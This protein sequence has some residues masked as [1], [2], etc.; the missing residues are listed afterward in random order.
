LSPFFSRHLDS[1]GKKNKKIK[2]KKIIYT[3]QYIVMQ[4]IGYKRKYSGDSGPPRKTYKKSARAQ[5]KPNPKWVARAARQYR[6]FAPETKYFDT[7]FAASV[8]AAGTSWAD[9]E[10]PMTS[11]VNS[12]GAVAAYTDSALIPSAQGTGYGQVIGNKYKL[13]AL[14]VKGFVKV[15]ILS[16]QQTPAE[17]RYT[18]IM[19]VMD[20]QPNGAQAQGE[21][22]MQ[23]MGGGVNN[24]SSYMRVSDGAGRRFVILG[25][26]TMKMDSHAIIRTGTLAADPIVNGLAF[27]PVAFKFAY[28]PKTPLEVQVKSGNATPTVAGLVNTNIFLLSYTIDAAGN[29]ITAAV[30][31]NARVYY[32][33]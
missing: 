7:A 5:Y 21:D 17:A 32:C 29:A 30:N 15:A 6:A 11:Y 1:A 27:Q 22:I 19:L 10:V 28:A 33:D 8:L 26:K 12:S 2:I 13:K 25:D 24:L 9:T 18:R 31:G 4:G 3:K 23:D 14:R 20:T 16:A